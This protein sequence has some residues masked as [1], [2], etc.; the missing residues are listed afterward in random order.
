[1]AN[2]EVNLT[3]RVRTSAGIRFCQVVLAAN[4]RVKP[5]TVLVND[6]PEIDREGADHLGLAR[7]SATRAAV[8]R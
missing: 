2:R 4:G 1:M 7:R 3:K 5:D 6:K 8:G